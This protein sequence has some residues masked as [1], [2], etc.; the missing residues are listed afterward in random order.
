[1]VRTHYV[2]AHDPET[3]SPDQVTPI[4]TRAMYLMAKQGRT[5][6]AD[7]EHTTDKP[8]QV[9]HL[10]NIHRVLRWERRP[11]DGSRRPGRPPR[12][13]CRFYRCVGRVA[14]GDHR[15]W[16]AGGIGSDLS[17][18]RYRAKVR[19][20]HKNMISTATIAVIGPTMAGL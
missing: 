1:M 19:G 9:D 17:E 8:V 11:V 13:L 2:C 15:V 3:R 5:V 16:E 12:K 20:H 6:N 14:A 7:P 10:A 18:Y 4:I